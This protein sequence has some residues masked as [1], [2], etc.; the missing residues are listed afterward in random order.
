MPKLMPLNSFIVTAHQ[1]CLQ[2]LVENGHE[3]KAHQEHTKFLDEVEVT[4]YQQDT[5]NDGKYG[6]PDHWI[7]ALCPAF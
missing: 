1:L 6:G 7:I 2:G 4:P 3:C 5:G